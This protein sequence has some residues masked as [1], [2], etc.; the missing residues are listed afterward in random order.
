[1]SETTNHDSFADFFAVSDHFSVLALRVV[2]KQYDAEN[3]VT[4]VETELVGAAT[5]SEAAQH[6][7]YFRHTFLSSLED[8]AFVFVDADSAN[9]CAKSRIDA[10]IESLELQI[11]ELQKKRD[12]VCS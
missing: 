11:R 4:R 10:K 2:E 3:D 5:V 9:Q 12:R 1:M 6:E 7:A 8:S